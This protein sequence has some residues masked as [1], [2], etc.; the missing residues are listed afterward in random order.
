MSKRVR[1]AVVGVGYFG[2][3]HARH[4]A[5]HRE[6]EL[7]AV[8]DI[9]RDAAQSVAGEH[10]CLALEDYRQL[11]GRVDAAVVAVPTPEHFSV[12]R[13]L[14]EAGL[15]VLV[16]KPLTLD[17]GSAD[18]L[19]A[20]AATRGV[21]LQ[22]GHIERYS[23]AF[24]TLAP[25]IVE[26][27]Y[28]ESYRIAPWR[29]RGTEADVIFDLMIHDI[30][31]IM[32]LVRSPVADVA[33]VGTPLYSSKIDLANARISF[34]SGC[35]AT[36]TASR[37]SHKTERTLRIFQPSGYVVC[38][39]AA[40]KIVQY[41]LGTIESGEASIAARTIDVPEEDSLANE[42]ADFISCIAKG[43]KPLVDG[44]VGADAV[45]VAS[46]MHECIDANLRVIATG[47]GRG[48]PA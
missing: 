8:V 32:G 12:A 14:I 27:R 42:I 28:I 22:V 25:L 1:I 5:G 23:A 15:H 17:V 35:V 3:F 47:Q 9:D 34:S 21:L 40:G 39:F 31:I 38:D 48:A 16:E 45:R 13:D 4:I 24:R 20:L 37:V 33:A 43:R 7:V 46:R 6:A 44:R 11:V 19:A 29:E 10:R 36:V 41:T 26:P 18:Q 30:D 2:R